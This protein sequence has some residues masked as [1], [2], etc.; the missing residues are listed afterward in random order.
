M[1]GDIV[2]A[3]LYDLAFIPGAGGGNHGG[4]GFYPVS[5]E[6]LLDRLYLDGIESLDE[7]EIAVLLLFGL[8]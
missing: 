5:V 8:I 6:R 4:S 3:D 1:F 2:F 7:N